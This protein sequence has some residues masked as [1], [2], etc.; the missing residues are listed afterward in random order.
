MSSK[1][2]F[3]V[4]AGIS[5]IIAAICLAIPSRNRI[6]FFI[7]FSLVALIFEVARPF[8]RTPDREIPEPDYSIT[9][10]PSNYAPGVE[11]YGVKWERDFE[12]YQMYFRN[13]SK[14]VDIHDLRVDADLLG[15]IVKYQ[16]LSQQGCENLVVIPYDTEGGGIGI[17]NGPIV[18]TVK[19]Y[20][21]NLKINAGKMFPEGHFELRLIMKIIPSIPRDE[22]RSGFFSVTY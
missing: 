18:K 2:L 3:H 14:T 20:S 22:E 16:V 15:G 17:K 19:S 4:I 13:K 8:L 9:Y 12:E 6:M 10:L 1:I 11:I 7:V 21:N 5:G